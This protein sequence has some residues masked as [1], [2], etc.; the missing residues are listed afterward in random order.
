MLKINSI[1]YYFVT[2][3]P[4]KM[5]KNIIEETCQFYYIYKYKKIGLRYP[6]FAHEVWNFFIYLI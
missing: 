1:T 6:K 4:N 3:K 2:S 5:N